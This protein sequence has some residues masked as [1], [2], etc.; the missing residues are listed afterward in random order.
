MSA[1]VTR[2]SSGGRGCPAEQ[3]RLHEARRAAG[4]G[5]TLEQLI[6]DGWE[7]LS[8]GGLAACLVCGDELGTSGLSQR[9]VATVGGVAASCPECAPA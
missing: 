5:L 9:T 1:L 4:G 2:R 7:D 6:S 3:R 8:V